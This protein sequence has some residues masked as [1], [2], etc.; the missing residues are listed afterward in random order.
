MSEYYARGR[1]IFADAT[2]FVFFLLGFL[3]AAPFAWPALQAAFENGTPDRGLAVFIARIFGA[4]L[5]VGL[6]GYVLGALGGRIWQAAHEWLRARHPVDDDTVQRAS[7]AQGIASAS[8]LPEAKRASTAVS[9]RV[10]ALPSASYAMFA[11][12]A[13]RDAEDRRYLE[14]VTTDVETV[15]AWDGLE[16]AG[17]ARLLSD[18]F[19]AVIITDIAIDPHYAAADIEAALIACAA[20]RV[21]KGGRLVRVEPAIAA[22]TRPR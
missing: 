2:S 20:E 3:G 19:G 18:G 14:T 10:G 4:G 8:A 11:Q 9:C 12:R 1:A 7:I 13:Q 15:T 21:P 5:A 16:V 22:S 17:V 6:V